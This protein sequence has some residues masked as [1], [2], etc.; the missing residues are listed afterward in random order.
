M[1]IRENRKA[2][3]NERIESIK[4][5]YSTLCA[6]CNSLAQTNFIRFRK[7]FKYFEQF[8]GV[9]WSVED[10]LR[11]AAHTLNWG[12]KNRFFCKKFVEILN[13][14][15]HF[16]QFKMYSISRSAAILRTQIQNHTHYK[17]LWNFFWA[18]LFRW[19]CW[20]IWLWIKQQHSAENLLTN[21][22]RFFFQSHFD[23]YRVPWPD[24][25]TQYAH[26]EFAT[27]YHSQIVSKN[28]F[29]SEG[30]CH[31]LFGMVYRSRSVLT[32]CSRAIVVCGTY[33]PGLHSFSCIAIC[34]LMFLLLW[35]FSLCLLWN[36]I[37]NESYVVNPLECV[38]VFHL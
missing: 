36:L 20:Q 21:E 18:R 30:V 7:S 23:C 35:F 13:F 11:T 31:S 27:V 12:I 9:F 5:K 28:C 4:T 34:A 33:V 3:H 2:T 24:S 17:Y 37:W 10:L 15:S 29:N 26:F 19:S 22:Q 25:R 8:T 38:C 1:T 6:L 32:V 14:E 16:G